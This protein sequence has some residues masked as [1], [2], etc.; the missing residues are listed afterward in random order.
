MANVVGATMTAATEGEC[1]RR[2][3]I[4]FEERD[5]ED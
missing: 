4:D 2:I 3:T 5:E 1:M